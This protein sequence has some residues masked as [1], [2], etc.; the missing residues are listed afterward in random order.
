M[1]LLRLCLLLFLSFSALAQERPLGK[2]ADGTE[3]VF[4]S[5]TKGGLL[6]R[7]QG[8]VV[9]QQPRPLIVM[10]R[11][12]EGAANDT[13]RT[14]SNSYANLR[15]N[16]NTATAT[17]VV[18]SRINPSVRYAVT[19]T[20]QLEGDQLRLNRVL[21]V[22][23]NGK[24]DEGFVSAFWL[25]TP[26]PVSRADSRLFL[27]GNVY[28]TTENLQNA[29][30]GGQ[31]TY[32]KGGGLVQVREDRLPAPLADLGLP[33]GSFLTLLNAQP[34][35]Q[36]TNADSEDFRSPQQTTGTQKP[37]PQSSPAVL[38]D[39]RFRF[40]ALRVRHGQRTTELGYVFPGSEG[41]VT[42]R[43]IVYPLAGERYWRWRLH[44]LKAGLS[45]TYQLTF[46]VGSSGGLAPAHRTD[47]WRWAWQSL[48][49]KV[50]RH[51]ITQLRG[52]LSDFLVKRVAQAPDGRW[53]FPYLVDG[54]DNYKYI[55]SDA[56]MGFCGKNI[57]TSYYLIEEAERTGKPQYREVAEKVI[58]SFTP[59]K[60]N[61]PA[62][63]GFDLLTGKPMVTM[64]YEGNE[65]YLRPLTDDFKM[66]ANLLLAER[67]RG[68]EH[69]DWLAWAKSFA[70]WLLTQQRPDGGLPRKWEPGTGRVVMDA[71]QS[72]YN[73][74]PFLVKMSQLTNDPKYLDAAKRIGEFS[75]QSGHE[76][77]LFV[78]GTIDNP[79]VIDKE[80]GT[81]S[82]EGYLALYESTQDKRWLDRARASAD[83]AETWMYLWNVPIPADADPKRL[84]VKP[85][86]PSTGFQLISTGHSLAD[87]YMTFDV[88]EYA[89]LYRYTGD[90]HY[91][92]VAQLLLHNTKSL[93]AL[94][95]HRY[96]LP[97]LGYQQEHFGFGP[98]RGQG[99]HR[100]WLPWVTTSHLN[101]IVGLEQFDKALFDELK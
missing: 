59:I 70:D 80:A 99:M 11:S 56:V 101:G 95:D 82:T 77:G 76:R 15:I 35:G 1:P 69:A 78:G 5:P 53:G 22:S 48:Q 19:D 40:G 12:R 73:A 81:L 37:Q 85:G 21:T 72:S 84:G 10:E 68:R 29:A 45:Q 16:G 58:N 63:E 93:I 36:T 43:G 38:I 87:A 50:V 18:Q 39:D 55:M 79:N 49:P 27:P 14:S 25:E 47:T 91:R 17:G 83:F 52:L 89:K 97:D 8:K 61:P 46:R 98:A 42:Y 74:L 66:M 100:W 65:I 20:Y 54:F 28:G 26:T 64:F 6:L 2:L 51:D 9:W 94:P 23:G 7:R 13:A 86:V 32:T 67:K 88:D 71:P 34:N 30:I 62:A 4:T 24:A 41:E 92:A 75:W 90:P 31:D 33:D 44:P 60:M 3:V 57:E 96:D